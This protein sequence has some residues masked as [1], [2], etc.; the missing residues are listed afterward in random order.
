M[1]YCAL[2]LPT[3]WSPRGA[4]LVLQTRTRVLNDELR[5]TFQRWYPAMRNEEIELNE[6]A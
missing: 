4:H 1:R 2:P 6:V 3:K 5:Q